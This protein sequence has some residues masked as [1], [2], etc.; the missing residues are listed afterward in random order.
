MYW[1]GHA[2]KNEAMMLLAAKWNCLSEKE[3]A[4]YY[5]KAE[6]V[7][8]AYLNKVWS[9][10]TTRTSKLQIGSNRDHWI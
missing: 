5:N 3:K 4:H 9:V 1:R 2:Q 10:C 7:K 6:E 8:V